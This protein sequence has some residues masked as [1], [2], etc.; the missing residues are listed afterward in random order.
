M[1]LLVVRTAALLWAVLE[2]SSRILQR[3]EK[4]KTFFSE[5][6]KEM[7][8]FAACFKNRSSSA[9][10]KN[11][12]KRNG[13]VLLL[14]VSRTALLL[15]L[16][17][18]EFKEK[19][20]KRSRRKPSSLVLYFLLLEQH[21]LLSS[22]NSRTAEQQNRTSCLVFSEQ[23]N[24]RT[25]F[26]NSRT[27][28]LNSRTAFLNKEEEQNSPSFLVLSSLNSKT[29][30]QKNRTAF[31]NSR[32]ASGSPCFL[33]SWTAPLLWAVLQKK[34]GSSASGSCGSFKKRCC[35]ETNH[36]NSFLETSSRRNGAVS[37]RSS[38][39]CFKNRS[40]FLLLVSRTA[41]RKPSFLNSR[42]ASGSWNK[43]QAAALVLFSFVV[44]MYQQH[45]PLTNKH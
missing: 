43:Q 39:A 42:T 22:L 26:L 11:S 15:L 21:H 12:K 35:S 23:Q 32:T 3:K 33:N 30:E 25:A 18:E 4:K 45:L 2:T 7:V 1:P 19:K 17:F 40:S 36:L 24:S 20:K 38:S 44:L 16:C 13:V 6:F 14:L 41:Q 9:A 31:L 10:S 37:C 8:L 29:A 5:F 28:F 27:A 34:S